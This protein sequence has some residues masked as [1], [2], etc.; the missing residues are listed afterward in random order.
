[1][2]EVSKGADAETVTAS[3]IPGILLH[4]CL[5]NIFSVNQTTQRAA[6]CLFAQLVRSFELPCTA[7]VAT[8]DSLTIPNNPLAFALSVSSELAILA[9][10]YT[11][12]FLEHC[13]LTLSQQ[14][15]KE[16]FRERPLPEKL[17]TTMIC[18][19]LAAAFH[20]SFPPVLVQL[21]CSS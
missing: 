19:G 20:R 3:A 6:Y 7:P 1:M 17:L 8:S 11:M 5:F 21:V 14:V 10:Q 18:L 16:I 9:P 2:Q 4:L 12:D 15:M 13:S